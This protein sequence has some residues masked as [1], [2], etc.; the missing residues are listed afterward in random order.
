M[1][2]GSVAYAYWLNGVQ[3]GEILYGPVPSDGRAIP[4]GRSDFGVEVHAGRFLG[5]VGCSAQIEPGDAIWTPLYVLA[6]GIF[7]PFTREPPK[8]PFRLGVMPEDDRI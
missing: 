6:S 2:I 7:D 8:W 4:I 3:P 1:R 5:G